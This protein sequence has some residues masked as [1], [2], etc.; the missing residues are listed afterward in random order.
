LNDKE[1]SSNINDTNT[2]TPNNELTASAEENTLNTEP[3]PQFKIMRR[4]AGS[5]PSNSNNSKDN[6]DDPQSRKNMTFEERKSA[7][8]EARARIFQN[9]ESSGSSQQ[10]QE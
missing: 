5:S 10:Q 6:K 8:E 7:Y 9:L 1:D 3:P 4:S 2:N